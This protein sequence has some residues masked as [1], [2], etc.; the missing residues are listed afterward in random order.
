MTYRSQCV[1]IQLDY[2][3]TSPL[4]LKQLHHRPMAHLESIRLQIVFGVNQTY[5]AFNPPSV[6]IICVNFPD[7]ELCIDFSVSQRMNVLHI[8]FRRRQFN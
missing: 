5:A 6:E 7:N 2:S 4:G 1:L 8:I 3:L